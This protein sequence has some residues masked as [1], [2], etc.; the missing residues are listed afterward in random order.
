MLKLIADEVLTPLSIVINQSLGH[1]QFLTGMKI[2]DVL[3]LFKSKDRSLESNYRPIS[4]LTTMSK[5]LE[6]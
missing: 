2:A 5:V 4:L 6:K 1:G 3:P